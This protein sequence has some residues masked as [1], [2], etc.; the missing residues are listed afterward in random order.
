MCRKNKP[1]PP[2]PIHF[3]PYLDNMDKPSSPRLPKTTELIPIF[4]L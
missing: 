4:A 2:S 3:H 1:L